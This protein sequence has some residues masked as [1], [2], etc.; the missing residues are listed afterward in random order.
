MSAQTLTL[1]GRRFVVLPE[2]DYLKLQERARK[3]SD[4]QAGHRQVRPDFAADAMRE[5]RAYRK[6]RKAAN[7]TDVQPKLGL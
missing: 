7:W 1:G 3:T 5:L 4:K 2:R 6:T